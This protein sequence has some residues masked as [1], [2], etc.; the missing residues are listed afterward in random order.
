MDTWTQGRA[1]VYDGADDVQYFYRFSIK[2]ANLSKE[3]IGG[4]FLRWVTY[5]RTNTNKVQAGL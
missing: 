2:T 3:S 5:K 1:F 4:S